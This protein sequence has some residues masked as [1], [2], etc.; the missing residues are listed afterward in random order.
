MNIILV[1]F[2]WCGFLLRDI[3]F[4]C[5]PV[6]SLTAFDGHCD[7]PVGWTRI[8]FVVVLSD[9]RSS[10][11]CGAIKHLLLNLCGCAYAS[12]DTIEYNRFLIKIYSHYTTWNKREKKKVLNLISAFLLLEGVGVVECKN[13]LP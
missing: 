8:K 5:R 4:L 12:M 11:R 3:R 10:L 1:S 2:L 6:A 9:V 7:M 13:K